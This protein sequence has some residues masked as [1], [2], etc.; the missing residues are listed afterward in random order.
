MF[1]F[2]KNKQCLENFSIDWPWLLKKNYL[3]LIAIN[4]Y[5]KV[6]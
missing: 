2:V 3:N 5:K 1:I 6:T 4:F